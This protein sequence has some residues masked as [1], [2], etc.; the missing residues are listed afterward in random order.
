MDFNALFAQNEWAFYA[1]RALV[2]GG[3][4]LAFAFA[5]VQWRGSSQR[6]M[7][8]LV[9]QLDAARAET[10]SLAQLTQ[11]LVAQLA[12][13]EE[14]IEDRRHLATASAGPAPRGYE[15]ALQMARNGA[16]PDQIT[17]ASGVTR[18]EAQLL[19][20]LHNPVRQAAA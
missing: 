19:A 2:L 12:A 3:A 11:E 7:Q 5:L 1:A 14:R 6:D 18:H 9:A 17:H 4:L 10:H 8:L 20:R 15:L 16:T 13:F